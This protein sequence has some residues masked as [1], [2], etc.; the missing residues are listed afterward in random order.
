[1][2]SKTLFSSDKEDWGTPLW[3]FNYLNSVFDFTLDPCSD[4]KNNLCKK[5]YTKENCVLKA[6]WGDERAFVNPPYGKNMGVWIKKASFYDSIVLVP[7]RTDT[8]WFHLH[9]LDIVKCYPFFIRGRLKFQGATNSAP[10]PSMLL[11]FNDALR[12]LAEVEEDV[13]FDINYGL[14]RN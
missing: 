6:N 14:K 3:L 10:F 9:C 11:F 2:V 13:E 4:G 5:F 7:A 1:M 8:K 12:W